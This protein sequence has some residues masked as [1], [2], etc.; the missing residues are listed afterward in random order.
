MP[1]G[2][3]D[4][5][6]TPT[7]Q[8][9]TL[10]NPSPNPNPHPSPS[11][12]PNR[13]RRWTRSPTLTLTLIL[14]LALALTLTD[15]AGGH[16]LQLG[17][18]GGLRRGRAQH[19]GQ[20]PRRARVLTRL[21]AQGSVNQRTL[22]HGAA[23]ASPS[24]DSSTDGGTREAALERR[25]LVRQRAPPT[26]AQLDPGAAPQ[27]LCVRDIHVRGPGRFGLRFRSRCAPVIVLLVIHYLHATI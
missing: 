27:R 22:S 23:T 8:V 1:S 18:L 2:G 12:N 13:P 11:P 3:L 5:A 7:A 16:A 17:L 15:R 24:T 14:T 6:P 21:H 25:A 9:D 20:Q 10:S 4:R 19:G 26:G